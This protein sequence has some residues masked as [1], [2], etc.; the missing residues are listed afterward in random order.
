MWQPYLHRV[1]DE[2]VK[3]DVAEKKHL[4]PT[5]D[6]CLVRRRSGI[7]VTPRQHASAEALMM[8]VSRVNVGPLPDNFLM[9][10]SEPFQRSFVVSSFSLGRL[11]DIQRLTSAIHDFNVLV[12]EAGTVAVA[13]KV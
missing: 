11:A 7:I 3:V 2:H 10:W 13:V 4:P 5:I 6:A 9:L 12:A 8:S 1:I